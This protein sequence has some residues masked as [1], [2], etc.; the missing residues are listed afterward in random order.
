MVDTFKL[1]VD[2]SENI[3]YYSDGN[4]YVNDFTSL[5]AA[6][7]WQTIEGTTANDDDYNY[8]KDSSGS[9]FYM[10]LND[11][12]FGWTAPGGDINYIRGYARIRKNG[13]V[14]T[15]NLGVTANSGV[16][17]SFSN[18]NLPITNT[19]SNYNVTWR[20]NPQTSVA[21]TWS[22]V[23]SIQLGI[24]YSG[25]SGDGTKFDFSTSSTQDDG[26]A[27]TS[28]YADEDYIYVACRGDGLRAY[29]FDGTTI[30]LLDDDDNA[31]IGD[32]NAVHGDDN[33]IF[34]AALSDGIATYSFNGST[35]TYITKS[36]AGGDYYD[37]YS[38]GTYIYAAC[39]NDGLRV[40]TFAGGSFNLVTTK[41]DGGLYR[42]VYSDG[43]YI[44][45]ACDL[46]GIR[47]YTFNG[48][49]LS[50]AGERDD[51][52]NYIN[53]SGD[54]TYIYAACGNVGLRVYSFNGTTFSYI[55]GINNGGD[56][57]ATYINNDYI[58]TA[59]TSGV[60][61]YVF[62]SDELTLVNSDTGITA[63]GIFSDG[64]YLYAALNDDGLR[65]YSLYDR[66]LD[67]SQYYLEVNYASTTKYNIE[68]PDK[69]RL[70]H[71]RNTNR[72]NL[73]NDTFKTYDINRNS[74]KLTMSGI[75][76]NNPDTAIDLSDLTGSTV[77]ITNLGSLEC[78]EGDY[79][80]ENYTP[81]KISDIPKL[82]KWN[83]TLEATEL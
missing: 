36:D 14:D 66:Y 80:I 20:K 12:P 35:L 29:S 31:A 64:T 26:D 37:V 38:D 67:I 48:T 62:C 81:T 22:D 28:I 83:M 53:V 39:G 9:D 70:R 78:F 2:T 40:Y 7:N 32:Y 41:D 24:K 10:F 15:V 17:V 73:W 23:R 76:H 56:Y 79:K 5:C 63:Y 16:S 55:D 42:G 82:Y 6:A 4:G 74:K 44:Y 71:T 21:W 61:G 54:G 46:S 33:N 52:G 34:I 60:R 11:L 18:I 68:R 13:N 45:T 50:L 75:I 8:G 47:A 25:A 59:T 57:W 43:T 27:Y 72:I 58:Y 3:L 19:F 1:V 69:I 30:T 51:S 77:S 65:A 49:T